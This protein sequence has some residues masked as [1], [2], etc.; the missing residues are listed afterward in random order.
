MKIF[1]L[2]GRFYE[3]DMYGLLSIVTSEIIC[4][5]ATEE[6]AKNEIDSFDDKDEMIKDHRG[7]LSSRY[8]IS[9]IEVKE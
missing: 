7:G 4:Y 5:H 6:G 1:A 3:E 9:C 8:F 2:H